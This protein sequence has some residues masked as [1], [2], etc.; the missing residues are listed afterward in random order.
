M[1]AVVQAPQNSESPSQDGGPCQ[2]ESSCI[3]N[4]ATLGEKLT[5]IFIQDDSNVWLERSTQRTFFDVTPKSNRD[6]DAPPTPA[7]KP[8]GVGARA[9]L[10]SFQL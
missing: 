10:Q 5:T 8:Q 2:N 4:G 3:C 9:L 7:P 6:F 1:L